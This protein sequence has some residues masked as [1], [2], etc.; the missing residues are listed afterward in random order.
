MLRPGDELRLDTVRFQLVAPGMD[1]R[2]QAAPMRA[3]PAPAPQASGGSRAT[4]WVLV[5]V[6]VLLLVAGA[7]RYVGLF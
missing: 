4:L 3:A 1:A 7:A 2:Q 5:A 6:V